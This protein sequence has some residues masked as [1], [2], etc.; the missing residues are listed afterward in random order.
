MQIDVV[1]QIMNVYLLKYS[2][3]GKFIIFISFK[4]YIFI[5][6]ASY[7]LKVYLRLCPQYPII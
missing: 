7:S 2:S 3:Y 1:V 4:F 5:C 6:L